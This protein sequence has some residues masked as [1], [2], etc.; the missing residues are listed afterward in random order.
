MVKL[1]NPLTDEDLKPRGGGKWFNEGVYPVV[2]AE[3]KR[4]KTDSGKEYIQIDVL[5]EE[6]QEGNA[7]LWFT[8]DKASKYALSILAGIAVHNKESEVEKE[9]VR[10][11][12][13]KITDT[14]SVDDKFLTRYKG[15]DAWVLVYEDTNGQQKPGGGYY[16]RTDIYGYEPKPK[17]QTAEQLVADFKTNGEAVDTDEIPF[18]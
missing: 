17:Q 1:E 6:D 12:F 18:E 8:T 3:A 10:T 15:M 14:D 7:R 9:K 16:K 2:I 13:K 11:T 5:G 4:G